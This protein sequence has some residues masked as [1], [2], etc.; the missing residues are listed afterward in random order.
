MYSLVL[1]ETTIKL[2]SQEDRNNKGLKWKPFDQ[3]KALIATVTSVLKPGKTNQASISD[4]N[5]ISL[6]TE[7]AVP[8]LQNLKN[9]LRDLLN[10]TLV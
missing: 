10:Q 9:F 7:Q 5:W 8:E 3:E 6:Q 2:F 4:N 1:R